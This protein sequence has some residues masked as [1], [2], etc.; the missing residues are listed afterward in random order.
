MMNRRTF[1]VTSKNELE[2]CYPVMKELRPQLRY[3]DY[4]SIYEDS[5]KADGYEIVAIEDNDQILALMGYRFLTDYVRGRH[6]YIDDLVTTQKIRSQG[7]G[8]ELLKLAESIAEKN[9]CASLRLCT[10]IENER[11]VIFYERNGWG[12]RSFAFVKKLED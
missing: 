5:H 6:L 2:R 8:A 1:T 4:L 9:G 11:G 12:K 7:L 3:E 10:G